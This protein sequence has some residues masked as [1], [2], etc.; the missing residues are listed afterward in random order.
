MSR[1]VVSVSIAI[2]PERDRDPSEGREWV[3]VACEDGSIWESRQGD[4]EWYELN[5]PPESGSEG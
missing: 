3:V 4:P 5:G 2:I 1:K